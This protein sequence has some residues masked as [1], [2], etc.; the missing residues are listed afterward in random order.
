MKKVLLTLLKLAVTLGGVGWVVLSV[1]DELHREQD[2]LLEMVRDADLLWLGGAL[3]ITALSMVLSA[4]Q[5]W[6]LLRRQGIECPLPTAV[7][8][9]FVGLFFNTFM[10][11][12]AG[13]DAKKVYDVYRGER[14]LAGGLTATLFD[15][16]FGLFTL[17]AVGCAAGFLL[18]SGNPR[19][20]AY[21][22]PCLWILAAMCCFFA[23]VFS[24]RI[25]AFFVRLLR[26][27]RLPWAADRFDAVR[28]RFH[29]Y[30]DVRL[31]CGILALS[32]VIQ[33]TRVLVH[34]MLAAALGLEAPF[35]V[36]AFFVPLLGVVSALP[37]SIGGFGPREALAQT[38]FALVAFTPVE[39]F[40]LTELS[41]LVVVLV[42]LP[43]GIAFLA[44]QS[45]IGP[46]TGSR[47][48][49]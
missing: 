41:V 32:L 49:G 22:V 48:E 26:R 17:D 37:V 43:G 19:M 14:D 39:S 12:N 24:R 34:W 6:W 11:G 13:G 47:T 28:R 1:R 33:F 18:A 5:W 15:R 20:A 4:V 44:A 29:L 46:G 36:Y 45:S 10:P 8:R 7:K 30:R 2:A 25:G 3:L 16:V 9:Y 38:L 27:C 23:A 35:A 31:W 42:S 21:L 40:V